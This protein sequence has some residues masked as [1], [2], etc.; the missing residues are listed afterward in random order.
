MT[1]ASY[2]VQNVGNTSSS[3]AVKLFG[4]QPPN[5]NL[6]LIVTKTYTT[7][8][9]ENCQLGSQTT[10]FL[11]TNVLNPTFAGVNDIGDPLL[12]N[13]TISNS[14]LSLA[15]GEQAQVT[16]RAF[17][18]TPGETIDPDVMRSLV[19]GNVT[20]VIVAHPVN[21]QD[22]VNGSTFSPQTLVITTT[23]AL[24]DA[25]VGQPYNQLIATLG[26]TGPKS[27]TVI[28]DP[29]LP[30]PLTLDPVTGAITGAPGVSGTFTF[31]VQVSD[32]TSSVLRSFTLRILAPLTITTTTLPDGVVGAPYPPTTLA[33]TGGTGAV[34]WSISP[35]TALSALGLSFDPTSGTITGTPTVAT[36]GTS[37]TVTATDTGTP[38]QTTSTTLTIRIGAVLTITTAALPN[39]SQGVAYTQ[40]LTASGGLG[41][42]TWSIAA[43][44]LPPGLTLSPAGVIS[45]APTTAGTFTFT[46][47]V[48][49]SS[50]PQQ[51]ATK[52]F[53][54][55]VAANSTL[56]FYIQPSN[57][58]HAME[59][60]P[61][62]AVRVTDGSGM[63]VAGVVVNLTI[64]INPGGGVLS[65]HRS[66]ITAANGI[67]VFDD[68][69]I[70]KPGTG[71]QLQATAP[72][73]SGAT[74]VLSRLF[75]IK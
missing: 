32:A 55:T 37:F 74:P 70:N 24:P 63:P 34:T 31:T 48:V 71:Y 38:A 47:Q 39:A 41:A 22:A 16:L 50:V 11:V 23:G 7:P 8:V 64:A 40:T 62:P 56:T 17:S 53:T 57:T 35:A 45:G 43:G 65:G 58:L 33:F 54:I 66:A 28:S 21:T 30:S 9:Q 18:G 61:E 44:S 14:T 51:L 59:I 73:L 5:V 19:L 1:D 12:Q 6:Q 27:F 2:T 13:G 26:G 10:T 20:P 69:A 67:A 4:N 52:A 49:D 72:G 36:T 68:L 42:Y 46:I 29:S 3:Y 60:E 15:P 25:I 75:N